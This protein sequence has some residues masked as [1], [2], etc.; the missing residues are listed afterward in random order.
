M[1]ATAYEQSMKSLDQ[2]E[3]D[4]YRVII[5][6]RSGSEILFSSNGPGWSLPR[7]EILSRFRVAEQLTAKVHA[8]I[9]V[10]AYCLLDLDLGLSTSNRNSGPTIHA[11]MEAL[12]QDESAPPG[13]C[14]LPINGVLSGFIDVREDGLAVKEALHGADSNL[15][16]QYVGPFAMPGWLEQ[17]FEWVQTQLDPQGFRITGVIRQLNASSTFSLIRLETTGPAVWFKATGKP[18]LHERPISLSL[19]RLF[20]E[21]VPAILGVHP[22]WNGWLSKEALGTTLDGL[23]ESSVWESVAMELAKLQIASVGKCAELLASGCKDRRLPKLI[24]YINPFCARMTE[25]M[26]VQEKIPPEPLISSQLALLCERLKEACTLLEEFR[27]PATLGHTDFNPGNILV[28][29]TGCCFLDWAEGCVTHPFITFEYLREHARRTLRQDT[30][31]GERLARAYLRSWESFFSLDALVH[32]MAF[33]PLIAIFVSA[34]AGETWR[35]LDPV[36]DPRIAAY[37][38]SLTRRMYREAT[39]TVE[40]SER[41]LKYS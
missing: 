38:R 18:N 28:S 13:S 31:I 2:A 20:P 35:S 16:K 39:D 3:R 36:R 34:I 12:Q 29:S 11:I 22:T 15:S 33:S 9:G 32:A 7:L 37:F 23:A 40:R 30:P 8:E 17:L 4:T 26:A 21:Y 27:L 25:F 14:W 10:R 19:A 5:T 6:R 41:C 24:E 1:R